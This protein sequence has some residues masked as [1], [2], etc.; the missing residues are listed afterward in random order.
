MWIEEFGHRMG[1]LIFNVTD[2]EII[3]NKSL[4]GVGNTV[5]DYFEEHHIHLLP[6][7]V[8]SVGAALLA[9]RTY[10]EQR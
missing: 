7:E 1:G 2:L 9:R 3:E 8:H 5:A 6:E 10:A 4:A